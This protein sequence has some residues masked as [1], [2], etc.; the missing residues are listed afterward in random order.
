MM[1]AGK[2]SMQVAMYYA[3]DDIRIEDHPIPTIGPGDLLVK[4]EVCG[5]CGGETMEWYLASRAPKVLGH[6]PTGVVVDVGPGVT[7]FK[8][9]DRVFVHH[10]V[11]CMSCHFCHRGRYT[12]CEH[13]S[14]TKIEPGGFAEF[15]RVP[16]EIVQFDT[17]PL[18]ESVSFAAGTVIEPMACTLKGVKQTPLHPG[19]SVAIVGLGF[20][21]M[22]YLQLLS[23][24]QAG[25]IFGLDFSEWRLEKARSLGATYTI[26]PQ[27]ENAVEKLRD[28]NAGFGA[29]AVFV[30]A[31]NVAA[32]ETGLAL[33]EKGGQLHLGAPPPP[34]TEWSVDPNELYFSEIQI[35][36][37]YSAN[38]VD[39]QSVLDLLTARR[40][41]AEALI[42]HRFGL[43]GVEQAIRLLL[44]ADASLKS[45]IYPG[46][47]GIEIQEERSE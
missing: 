25:N 9:G 24:T 42:T 46:Q 6:E 5:L 18:P 17:L 40:L 19:D 14:K 28:L 31:P 12:L 38:H 39:T 47:R 15:F 43:D 35:N 34:G 37:T 20:M 8:P 1:I 32:W 7:K 21:G 23:L 16:A 11:P 45:I 26:N 27:R 10:H 36:S 29:D 33:C 4:T 44:E 2:R 13:F 3:N 30:T 22:C 41:D